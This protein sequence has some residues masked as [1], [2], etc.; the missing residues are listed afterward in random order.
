MRAWP[1][2][3][4]RWSEGYGSRMSSVIQS[5][6]SRRVRLGRVEPAAV[7]VLTRL[8]PVV[9]VGC[10]FAAQGAYGRPVTLPFVYLAL[11]A[12]VISSPLFGSFDLPY[13][14]SRGQ[15]PLSL[16]PA[17]CS[18]VLVRWGAIVA[19]LLFLAF[20]F[21][22]SALFPRRVLLTWFVITPGALCLLQAVRMRASWFAAHL[23]AR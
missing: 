19:G 9:V 5:L 13:L 11:L 21:N 22:V 7:A 1:G 17:A 8:D 10:L 20:A 23:P 16:L 18:R 15:N 6:P 12:F 3:R 2:C 4:A 14:A